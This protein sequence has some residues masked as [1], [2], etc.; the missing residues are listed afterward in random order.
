[1]AVP[2]L[3][4]MS[5]PKSGRTWLRVMLDELGIK[6]AY[7]HLLSGH[8][9]GRQLHELDMELDPR[10]RRYLALLRDPRDT[11]VSGYYQAA[12][13]LKNY[14]GPVSGFIRDPSHGIERTIGFN[15]RLAERCA[16]RT[17]CLVL[18][19]EQ[20]LAD[21]AQ[22][23]R[24]VGAFAG[25]SLDDATVVRIVANNT[26]ER[27]QARER[28]GEFDE[29]YGNILSG[30]LTE[31]PDAMKVRR[32]VVGGYRDELSAEDIAHVDK[33]VADADYPRR[34]DALIGANE[35]AGQ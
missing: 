29:R 13:R 27:M 21:P 24:R 7:T 30:R 34:M 17:D 22:A 23:L 1:M 4:V 12:L 11:V 8:Q 25:Y 32:G 5:Y 16:R 10:F 14:H 9:H 3:L 19:Y 15:L 18:T 26:F 6:A 35:K 33:A 20:M 28:A 31:V 2:E